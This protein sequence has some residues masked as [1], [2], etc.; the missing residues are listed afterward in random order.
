MSSSSKHPQRSRDRGLKKFPKIQ[1]L[2][3]S[4]IVLGHLL[5]LHQIHLLTPRI[6]HPVHGH[7][8]FPIQSLVDAFRN[9]HQVLRNV[10]SHVPDEGRGQNL[11]IDLQIK[12]I[13]MEGMLVHGETASFLNRKFLCLKLVS[14]VYITFFLAQRFVSFFLFSFGSG[15]GGGGGLRTISC[16]LI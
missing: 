14:Y 1:A 16:S 8:V 7:L 15:E 4:K 12:V 5:R 6:D 2:L 9:R 10:P 13:G 3:Q 11:Q